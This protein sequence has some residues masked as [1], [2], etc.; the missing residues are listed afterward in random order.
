MQV[1]TESVLPPTPPRAKPLQQIGG[2]GRGAANESTFRWCDGLFRFTIVSDE[3]VPIGWEVACSHPLHKVPGCPPCRN[4]ARFRKH[5]GRDNAERKLKQWCLDCMF[6]TGR[7]EHLYQGKFE[8][9]PTH[10]ELEKSALELGPIFRTRFT[11]LVDFV[12]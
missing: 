11:E 6:H 10:E 2:L 12:Q 4:T 9:P 5:G 3:G 1:P 7:K 8:D